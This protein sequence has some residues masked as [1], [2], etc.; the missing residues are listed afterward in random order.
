[1]QGQVNGMTGVGQ[2]SL[3]VR[4]RRAIDSCRPT[5]RA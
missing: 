2:V 3:L 4:A 5:C 1:M